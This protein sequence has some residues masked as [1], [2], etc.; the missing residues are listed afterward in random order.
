M[1]CPRTRQHLSLAAGRLQVS[2]HKARPSLCTCTRGPQEKT[3]T[4]L[5]GKTETSMVFQEAKRQPVSQVVSGSL[6]FASVSH[7]SQSTEQLCNI[8][9]YEVL[10]SHTLNL[11][12]AAVTQ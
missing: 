2:D 6:P 9:N 5:G 8:Q 10:M 11:T 3:D 7:R 1:S 4:S 12:G